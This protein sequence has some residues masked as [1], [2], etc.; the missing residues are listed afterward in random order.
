LHPSD[1]APQAR[2]GSVLKRQTIP[3]IPGHLFRLM[4]G[5]VEGS[6]LQQPSAAFNCIKSTTPS[7]FLAFL[8][9]LYRVREGLICSRQCENEVC[10]SNLFLTK[11]F[12]FIIFLASLTSAA[13]GPPSAFWIRH[14]SISSG[15]TLLFDHS[16]GQAALL[17]NPSDLGRGMR[18]TLLAHSS[19]PPT[20][21]CHIHFT[22]LSLTIRLFFAMPAVH[23]L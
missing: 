20:L 9:L 4:G 18:T 8:S 6:W 14:S 3:V 19:H 5:C 17:I 7:P 21:S 23:H 15:Q 11:A 1:T 12:R 16:K 22:R 13:F 2:S 10:L